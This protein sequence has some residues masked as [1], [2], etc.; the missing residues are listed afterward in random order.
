MTE[1]KI[2]ETSKNVF[3]AYAKD[4]DNWGGTPLVGGNVGGGRKERGNLTQL[5]TAG[6]IETWLDE[7]NTWIAF[8]AAGKN[9]AKTFGIIIED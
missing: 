6:L 3:L 9:Y 1:I 2:T 4:A 7:G 8:T 5:K